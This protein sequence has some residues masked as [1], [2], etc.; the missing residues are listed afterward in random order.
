MVFATLGLG[1]TALQR[2]H[3]PQAAGPEGGRGPGGARRV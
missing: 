1:L 2:H 3:H